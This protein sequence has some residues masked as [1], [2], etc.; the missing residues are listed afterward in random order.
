MIGLLCLAGAVFAAIAL[1]GNGFVPPSDRDEVDPA[2]GN[3]RVNELV[4]DNLGG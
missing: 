4:V 1:P 3:G 2:V